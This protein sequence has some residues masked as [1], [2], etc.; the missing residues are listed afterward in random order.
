MRQRAGWL[1][2]LGTGVVVGIAVAGASGVAGAAGEPPAGEDAERAPRAHPDP[3]YVLDH[4]MSL[5][6]GTTKPLSEYEGKVVLMVNTASRCGLTPQY[7]GLQALYETY[8]DKGLVV[9][10][11]PANQFGGQEPGANKQIAEFCAD[12][13]SVTFPMFEKIVVKGEGTHPLYTELASQP[14]PIG[15]APRWNFT[16]FLVDRTGRVVARFEPSVEPRDERVVT[17]LEEFLER[18]REPSTPAPDSDSKGS[19]TAGRE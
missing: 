3:A 12:H 15:G 1:G 19:E 16:K 10:G 11:F 8:R 5:I 4:E 13:Y 14:A 17:R 7:E 9:L 6:D 18:D 2:R